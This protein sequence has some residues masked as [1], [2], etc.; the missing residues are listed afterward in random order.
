MRRSPV[1]VNLWWG[2]SPRRV[3]AMVAT[4]TLHLLLIG[5]LLRETQVQAPLF[6]RDAIEIELRDFEIIRPVLPPPRPEG[7]LPPPADRLRPARVAQS[8][9]AELNVTPEPSMESASV[10]PEATD[11]RARIDHQR[12]SVAA[13]IARENAPAR[14]AFAGRSIDAMLPDKENVKLPS[15]RPKT[16]DGMRDTMR[17]LGNIISLG[18][19]QAATDYDAPMDL[20]TE[21]WENR[22]HS[23]DMADCDLE[24]ARFDAEMRRQ[25]C[26]FVKPPG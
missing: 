18:V 25:L 23:S 3:I 26:G 22:H 8:R 14:R 10:I 20:L 19:P 9:A 7:A 4:F 2:L 21:G 11:L 24:Y 12:R 5:W 6:N 1:A 17:K 15:F 13:D 16:H